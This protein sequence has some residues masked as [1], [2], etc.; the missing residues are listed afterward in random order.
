MNWRKISQ[1]FDD[2]S[3]W[4]H[5]I[6]KFKFLQLPIKNEFSNYQVRKHQQLQLYIEN[7]CSNYK[8]TL[9]TAAVNKTWL[10]Q[11]SSEKVSVTAA[12]KWKMIAATVK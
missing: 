8:K 7:D 9:A 1:Y 2:N 4:F 5:Q 10:Q 11:L 12:A 3:T 6:W